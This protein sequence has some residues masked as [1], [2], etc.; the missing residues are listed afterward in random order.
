MFLEFA[1]FKKREILFERERERGRGRERRR[2][3]HRKR[4]RLAHTPSHTHKNTR[5]QGMLEGEFVSYPLNLRA[6]M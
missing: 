4:K 2:Q 6:V 3:T 1:L 5:D